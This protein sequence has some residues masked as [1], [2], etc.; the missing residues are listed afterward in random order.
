MATPR[1]RPTKRVRVNVTNV[2]GASVLDALG[3][4]TITNDD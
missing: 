1:W 4:G 2:A 3:I